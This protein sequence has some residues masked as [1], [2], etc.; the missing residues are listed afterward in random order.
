MTYI[1]NAANTAWGRNVAVRQG[2]RVSQE[3][4]TGGSV[5]AGTGFWY[6]RSADA[7]GAL[8]IKYGGAE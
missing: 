5:P 1:R 8:V 4:Q 7:N 3:W 2:R 6:V